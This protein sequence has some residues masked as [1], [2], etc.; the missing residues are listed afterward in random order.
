MNIKLAA[1]LAPA[2]PR[3]PDLAL[4]VE[5]SRSDREK[6][7]YYLVP[8]EVPEGV[9]QMELRYVYPKADDCVIDLG[10]ADPSLGPFPSEK[11]LRG[12]SGGA[13]DRFVIGIDAA[14]PGFE[15]GAIPAGQWQALLGLY[16]VPAHDISVEISVFFSFEPRT[17]RVLA[18]P[19]QPA[20]R[21]AGWYCGDLQCH[22]FHSDAQ[23]SPQRLHKTALR[24]GLDFLAVTDHNTVSQ[25]RGYFDAASSDRLIFVPAYEF[26][27]EFGHGNVYGARE[28]FDFRAEDSAA[29]TGMVRRIRDSG[30]LFSINHDKPNHPWRWDVPDAI[31]CMEVWQSHWLAGNQ[32]SLS[33]YQQRLASGMR[34]T[35][36]GGS[37]F[38]QPAVERD[39]NLLTLARPTTFLWLE[40]LSVDGI[41]EALRAGRSFVT[42]R[43]AGPKLMISAGEVMMGGEIAA[44]TSR[45][46]IRARDAAGERVDIWD[47]NGLMASFDVGSDDWS[48]DCDISSAKGFVRAELVAVASRDRIVDDLAAFLGAGWQEFPE[49]AGSIDE[50]VRRALTSPIY[51]V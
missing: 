4:K 43:P 28:V 46:S 37:D 32:L 50:P 7:A 44:G 34:I 40:E 35:A 38:H 51:I 2:R 47:A 36:I 31:D 14:T 21:E 17:E 6:S 23:G 5:I 18:P 19:P 3:M 41:L 48:G 22:T 13:R 12:W 39:D 25:Q 26:T 20:R 1:T 8:F 9:T 27:T 11:G 30:A 42:E 16:R 15:A 45:L 29:V 10:A 33:R 49:W 24:E